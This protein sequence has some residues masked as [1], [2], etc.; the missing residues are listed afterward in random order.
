MLE[1]TSG[2]YGIQVSTFKKQS[3]CPACP[4]E[5]K[6]IEPKSISGFAVHD[7]ALRGSP[8]FENLILHPRTIFSTM[9]LD[10]LL[11]K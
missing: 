8:L 2:T 7:A 9:L 10:A 5:A 6:T 3:Y 11:K 1:H 4:G